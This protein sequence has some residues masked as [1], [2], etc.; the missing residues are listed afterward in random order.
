MTTCD[1][2]CIHAYV[3]VRMC[4]VYRFSCVVVYVDLDSSVE[5]E[6]SL[7]A[8]TCCPRRDCFNEKD[9][10]ALWGREREGNLEGVQ[11]ICETEFKEYVRMYVCAYVRMSVSIC[12]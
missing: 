9:V 7:P 5:A 11:D 1:S 2:T 6:A 10:S 3:G 8:P 4:V 12:M